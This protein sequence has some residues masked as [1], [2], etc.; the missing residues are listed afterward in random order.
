MCLRYSCVLC[1]LSSA[2]CVC[3]VLAFQSA[4]V[5][6]TGEVDHVEYTGSFLKP[7]ASWF[8]LGPSGFGCLCVGLVGVCLVF[9]GFLGLF[10]F[11][12]VG[13]CSVCVCAVYAFNLA[14]ACYT[15][16]SLLSRVCWMIRD[17]VHHVH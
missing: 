10:G 12:W 15:H 5:F 14:L 17:G 11:V 7:T 4:V 9:W 2:F 6:P 13:L 1:V 8:G 3:L 16:T